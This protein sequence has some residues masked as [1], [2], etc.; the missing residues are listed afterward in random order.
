MTRHLQRLRVA[1][2]LVA[3]MLSLLPFAGDVHFATTQHRWCPV[4]HH[5]EDIDGPAPRDPGPTPRG[6]SKGEPVPIQTGHACRVLTEMRP[7]PRPGVA[8]L[9]AAPKVPELPAVPP[10]PVAFGP[11]VLERAPKHGPPAI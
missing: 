11:A 4:H 5:I 9:V 1:S 10:V 3:G 8:A 2:A 7:V 6:L